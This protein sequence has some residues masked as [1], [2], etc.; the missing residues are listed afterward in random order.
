MILIFAQLLVTVLSVSQ[1][2]E[3]KAPLSMFNLPGEIRHYA[4]IHETAGG[5]NYSLLYLANEE[6]YLLQSRSAQLLHIA[7][8]SFVAVTGILKE[9]VKR[10]PP[11]DVPV[12][13]V[14]EIVWHHDTQR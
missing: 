2:L 9:R 11:Q 10:S 14:S 1:V 8:G 5:F 12:F 4:A 3:G 7:H 13:E 6:P